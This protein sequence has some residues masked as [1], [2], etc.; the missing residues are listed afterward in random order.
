MI[1][2][3]GLFAAFRQPPGAAPRTRGSFATSGKV[4]KTPLRG[5]APKNPFA[6]DCTILLLRGR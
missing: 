2:S 3:H 5:N 1:L 6:G 4:T